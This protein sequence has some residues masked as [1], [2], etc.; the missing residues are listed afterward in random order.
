MDQSLGFP[1][2]SNPL[3]DVIRQTGPQGFQTYLGQTAQAK[4]M[5]TDIF[6]LTEI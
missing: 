2:E 4:L 6:D 5:Q 3:A 1:A